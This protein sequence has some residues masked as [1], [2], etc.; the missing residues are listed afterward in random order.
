MHQWRLS[1]IMARYGIKGI[2]LAKK[3]EISTNTVSKLRTAQEMP[4]LSGQ[5]LNQLCDALNDLIWESGQSSSI[6]APS[7]LITYSYKRTR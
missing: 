5:K 1:E 7:D 6:I 3:L 4:Y 2:H